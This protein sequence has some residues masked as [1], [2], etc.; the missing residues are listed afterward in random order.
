MRAWSWMPRTVMVS[1][2]RLHYEE[3]P[4]TCVNKSGR[5]RAQAP[6]DRDQLK[7]PIF[8]PLP[9]LPLSRTNMRLSLTSRRSA[10]AP[11]HVAQQS[12]LESGGA[13]DARPRFA[14]PRFLGRDPF[15]SMVHRLTAAFEE[16]ERSIRATQ[17]SIR[18]YAC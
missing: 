1:M 16:H 5:P 6:F 18:S 2:Q 11:A 10:T 4:D 14:P 15:Q 7:C 12:V 17:V 9:L 13:F 3:L 8:T